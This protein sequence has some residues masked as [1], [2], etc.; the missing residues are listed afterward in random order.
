M[1]TTKQ[2]IAQQMSERMAIEPEDA[3]AALESLL[4]VISDG[5]V[6]G[7]YWELRNFGVFKWKQRAPR[8]GR[9]IHTGASVPVPAYRDVLFRPGKVM[10]EQAARASKI[11]RPA[12][13]KKK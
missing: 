10:L 5:L 4:S 1:T 6:E 9:N 7:G 8:T 3:I 11:A 12:P 2:D 13:R